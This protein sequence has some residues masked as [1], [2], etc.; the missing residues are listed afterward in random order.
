[1][2]T[3]R[4]LETI[5]SYWLLINYHVPFL[6]YE[7]CYGCEPLT[8]PSIAEWPQPALFWQRRNPKQDR[9][10]SVYT[11]WLPAV[12]IIGSPLLH[13]ASSYGS[14]AGRESLSLPIWICSKIYRL[15]LPA[16]LK[17]THKLSFLFSYHY[18]LFLFCS[19]FCWLFCVLTSRETWTR[20]I[21]CEIL[22]CSYCMC[23]GQESIQELTYLLCHC[24]S[25]IVTSITL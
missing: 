20:C 4:G 18:L 14:R 24:L 22:C 23:K 21:F 8:R 5:A 25:L 2:V 9:T 6:Y 13:R 10:P 15:F 11:K 16:L 3:I 19:S 12:A 7:I 17:N 1:M